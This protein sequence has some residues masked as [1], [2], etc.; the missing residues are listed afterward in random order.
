MP[1]Q[2][3]VALFVGRQVINDDVQDFACSRTGHDLVHEG[4]EIFACPGLGCFANDFSGGNFK[5]CKQRGC[6]VALVSALAAS[7]H[8]VF[9]PNKARQGA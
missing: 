5:G 8:L 9:G 2:P 4:Q 6:A 7:H 3:L 1:G